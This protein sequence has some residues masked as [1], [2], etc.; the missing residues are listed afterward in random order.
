MKGA[1]ALT[2]VAS[3][4]STPV[5]Q[6]NT[7]SGTSQ[8]LREGFCHRPR[9]KSPIE[10]MA[11]ASTMAVRWILPRFFNMFVP[12]LLAGASSRLVRRWRRDGRVLDSDGGAALVH[13]GQ[14]GDE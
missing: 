1:S 11:V 14:P 5:T 2:V 6:R 10:G 9:T 4:K 12:L 3:V 8:W 7:M 13:H